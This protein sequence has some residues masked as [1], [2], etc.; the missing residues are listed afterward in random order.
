MINQDLPRN[1]NTKPGLIP[2][3]IQLETWSLSLGGEVESPLNINY[4]QLN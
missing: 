3:T 4:E 1:I 2:L